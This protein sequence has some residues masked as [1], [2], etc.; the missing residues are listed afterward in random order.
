MDVELNKRNLL[1]VIFFGVLFL[2]DHYLE[3]KSYTQIQVGNF[4]FKIQQIPKFMCSQLC[5][6]QADY[7]RKNIYRNKRLPQ[8]RLGLELFKIMQNGRIL[9]AGESSKK[10]AEC[11]VVDKSSFVFGRINKSSGN[12]FEVIPYYLE[13][14]SS[15][16]FIEEFE[17][18]GLLV[19]SG[20]SFTIQ[21][22]RDIPPFQKPIDAYL[23]FDFQPQPYKIGIINPI[24]Y[25]TNQL[26]G[27]FY[28]K[29]VTPR[30]VNIICK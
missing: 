8:K 6:H 13:D 21:L 28:S 7:N 19:S 14:F 16:V 23:S 27:K 20:F 12:I 15:M 24:N 22:E 10:K 9:Y 1:F 30:W 18:F 25:S 2:L 29:L 17:I 5:Q 11:F 3:L 26:Q 4:L